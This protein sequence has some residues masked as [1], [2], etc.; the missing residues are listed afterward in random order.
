MRA[1][2]LLL[3]LKAPRQ[4]TVQSRPRTS[5]NSSDRARRGRRRSLKSLAPSIEE[6]V[7]S[8]KFMWGFQ[9]DPVKHHPSQLFT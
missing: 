6:R 7:L 8:G 5:D 4:E 9:V 2:L 3:L 1:V